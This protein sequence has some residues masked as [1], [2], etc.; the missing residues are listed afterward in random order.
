MTLNELKKTIY[1]T[2]PVA[3]FQYIRKGNA[4][5]KTDTDI[6]FEV[7]VTDMGDA[8]FLAEMSGKLMI[9]WIL[10]HE[11]EKVEG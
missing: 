9:R 3:K 5:Y 6:I 10:H 11:E 1:K 4:Y 8:D 7:P 2:N